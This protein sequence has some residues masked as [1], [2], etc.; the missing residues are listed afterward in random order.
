MRLCDRCAP[1]WG[2]DTIPFYAG[3]SPDS[4]F[5]LWNF[6]RS[7]HAIPLQ[8][9]RALPEIP[10]G[11]LQSKNAVAALPGARLVTT[12]EH[13]FPGPNLSTY[14]F[15]KVSTQRNIYRVPVP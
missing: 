5:L 2:V 14:A 11:G 4:K 3:W 6:A 1:P 7:M 12:E 8:P 10:A 9:G 15:M 13:A